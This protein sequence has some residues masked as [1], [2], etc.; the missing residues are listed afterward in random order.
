MMLE[1]ISMCLGDSIKTALTLSRVTLELLR[2]VL[3]VLKVL[4]MSETCETQTELSQ[5]LPK[6]DER[7]EMSRY[8]CDIL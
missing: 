7:N 6:Y 1:L 3:R 5:V 4:K 2:V 8:L